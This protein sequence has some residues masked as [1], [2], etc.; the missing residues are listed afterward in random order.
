MPN[1]APVLLVSL[2][3]RGD[4]MK[5]VVF[6]SLSFNWFLLILSYSSTTELDTTVLTLS[7]SWN[8]CDQIEQLIITLV[9]GHISTP[10]SDTL[11]R[12]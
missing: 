5:P 11:L 7:F 2:Y 8:W 3:G 9:I 4:S 10:L 6:Q 12:R 1:H